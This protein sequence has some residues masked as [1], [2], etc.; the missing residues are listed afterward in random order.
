MNY[1]QQIGLASSVGSL[2][3]GGYILSKY[4]VFQGKFKQPRKLVRA[5]QYKSFNNLK[6]I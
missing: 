3:F 4:A 5:R 2:I 6:L 1:K